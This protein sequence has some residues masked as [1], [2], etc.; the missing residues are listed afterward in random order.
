MAASLLST[1][2]LYV[3]PDFAYGETINS[4]IEDVQPD[5]P[6]SGIRVSYHTQKEI[7]DYVQKHPSHKDDKLTYAKKPVVKGAYDMGK[8]SEAT[9]NSALNMLKQIRYIAGISDQVTISE[10]YTELAQA[11]ALTNY[12]N[13]QLSHYPPKPAG[14]SDSL[15]QLGAEGARQS[16]LAWAS[17]QGR[18]LA[19]TIVDGWMEDGDSSNISRVGHR[20]WLLNPSMS[21]TGF[22]AVDGSNGTYSTVY[23]F[24]DGNT[25]AEEYG[26]CWPAQNM[27]TEYFG[28]AFPW[29]VSTGT[30]EEPSSVRVTMKNV[31]TGKV[32]KFSSSSSDGDFYV[33]NG[34]Y[35]QTGCIIFR[36]DK[37]VSYKDGDSY[38]VN[39]TG[40]AGPD[41]SYGVHFFDLYEKETEVPYMKA[42]SSVSGKIKLQWYK[43]SDADGYQVQYST[44]SKFKKGKN[45]KT[46]DT[47]STSLT[48]KK[49]KKNQR[50]YVRVRAYRTV[51]GKRV[52]SKWTKV[53]KL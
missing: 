7:S 11:A 39:I 19:G 47:K 16:N 32:W 41:I 10:Q 44:N 43:N 23:T 35:G 9:Q 51:K 14:M 53:L 1:S 27:P 38:Q 48:I 8:I 3:K 33:D 24:D 52:Y 21:A 42:Y 45:T 49:A 4:D 5:Q 46:K 26:V 12:A 50:Y 34:G 13:G 30:V 17:W 2:V 28:T 36:P 25:S 18:S 6:A 31:K 40:L 20:R 29:S 22:G 15:Y 37:G